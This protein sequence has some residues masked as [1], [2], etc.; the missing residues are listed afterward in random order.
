M[1]MKKALALICCIVLASG[2]FSG[3]VLFGS[4]ETK[5]Y[6]LADMPGFD[7][8]TRVV[9]AMVGISGA[10]MP[11][12][13]SVQMPVEGIEKAV[14]VTAVASENS[15]S[16]SLAS[17]RTPDTSVDDA[18]VNG[19]HIDPVASGKT[20]N[21]FGGVQIADS[22]GIRFCLATGAAGSVSAFAGKA[23]LQFGVSPA[24]GETAAEVY[25]DYEE[26]FVFE[27][28]EYRIGGDGFVYV[29][30][31][32][33]YPVDKRTPDDADFLRDYLPRVNAVKVIVTP[34]ATINDGDYYYIGGFCAYL[35]S[36]VPEGSGLSS[37]AAFEVLIGT[38]FSELFNDGNVSVEEIARIAQA[39]ENDYYGKPCGLM[40]QL[41]IAAGGLC[42]MDFHDPSSPVVR[43]MD[44]D[45]A[46]LGY[47]ICI[48]NTHGSHADHTDD[49]VAVQTDLTAAAG[50]FGKDV[51]ED[52]TLDAVIAHS[53]EIRAAGGDRAFLR[54]MHVA[55]ENARV[56]D[57][58]RALE[59]NDMPAFLKLVRES[60]NSSYK[61]LQN[62]HA[63]RTPERQELAVALAISEA[64]L[65]DEGAC[66]VHGG[67]FAGTIQAFVPESM[68]GRYC[69]AMDDAFG[70]GSCFPVR[71]CPAGSVQIL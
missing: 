43:K 53:D 10:K 42:H 6:I 28:P 1:K 36:D 51:L 66:R 19:V 22:V 60:G 18:F 69:R 52:V 12:Q 44:L 59:Q 25:S 71:V 62:V 50:V 30:F 14:R 37:S 65:G 29:P 24:R 58:V 49:Y 27:T 7:S 35:T 46:S 11:Q 32:D 55:A 38:I 2:I 57:E 15:N 70:E 48:T 23:R 5:N 68:V 16:F 67:G 33:A 63:G 40:D 21:V 26:G 56:A 41:T 20:Y 34:D 13:A 39:A 31:E 64:V 3:T 9:L 45:P 4:A 54:A 61:L 47:C 17:C 8:Y